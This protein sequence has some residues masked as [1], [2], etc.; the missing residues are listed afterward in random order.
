VEREGGGKDEGVDFLLGRALLDHDCGFCEYKVR[1]RSPDLSP[2]EG[3]TEL[4][5]FSNRRYMLFEVLFYS[6]I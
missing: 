2:G 4:E 1:D 3:L 6:D 5:S